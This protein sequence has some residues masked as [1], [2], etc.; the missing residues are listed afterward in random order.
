MKPAHDFGPGGSGAVELT[1]RYSSIDL[2]DGGVS[3]NEQQNITV[4]L[5]WHLNKNTRFMTNYVHTELDDP[6]DEGADFLL[7]RFQ[8]DF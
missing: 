4:G 8:I 2:E 3:G 5:N 1:A 6:V 7:F